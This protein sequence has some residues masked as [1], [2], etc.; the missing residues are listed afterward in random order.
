LSGINIAALA[1]TMV[2]DITVSP[3]LLM[4][5][6]GRQPRQPSA[7]ESLLKLGHRLATC[8]SHLRFKLLLK[9]GAPCLGQWRRRAKEHF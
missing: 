4:R 2:L 3:L 8:C 5:T 1:I 7:L 9:L 6:T